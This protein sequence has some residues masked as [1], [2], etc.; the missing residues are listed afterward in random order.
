MAKIKIQ[1]L[2]YSMFARDIYQE[3]KVNIDIVQSYFRANA[4]DNEIVQTLARFVG[5]YDYDDVTPTKI[6]YELNKIDSLMEEEIAVILKSIKKWVKLTDKDILSDYAQKLKQ[7]CLQQNLVNCQKQAGDDIDL[8]YDLMEKFEYKDTYSDEMKIINLADVDPDKAM[9]ESFSLFTEAQY[10]LIKKAYPAVEGWLSAQQIMVVGEPGGGK[11]LFMMG[12]AKHWCQLG[13]RGLYVALGDL[14]QASFII[15]LGAQLMGCSLTEAARRSIACMEAIRKEI[16][17][18][19]LIS[20]VPANK[21]AIERFMRKTKSQSDKFDFLIVDY[22]ANFKSKG[23]MNMYLQG[24]EIYSSLSEFTIGLKKLCMIGSQP[25]KAYYGK[26]YLPKEC[27]AESSKKQQF[28]DG[29]ITIGNRAGS[30]LPIGYL[31]FVKNRNGND[32][33]RVPYVRTNDGCFHEIPTEVYMALRDYNDAE[34][35]SPSQLEQLIE[36]FTGQYKADRAIA[37]VTGPVQSDDS[38]FTNDEQE[39]GDVPF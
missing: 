21:I 38:Y 27:A 8:F 3:A 12:C 20:C 19:L 34:E 37:K 25:A 36:K 4:K 30:S 26:S 17:P 11:S 16:G 2:A 24:G 14:T 35:I 15:R 7:C 18:N 22:D 39:N 5:D 33:V 10:E 28:I 29:M 23:D 9:K 13:K 32:R 31:A 6:E 1:D